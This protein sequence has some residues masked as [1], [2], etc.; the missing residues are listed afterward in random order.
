ML[1]VMTV[2]ATVFAFSALLPDIAAGFDVPVARAAIVPRV[3][4][5]WRLRSSPRSSGSPPDAAHADA[6]VIAAGLV[7]LRGGVD[8][9]GARSALRRCCSRSP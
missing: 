5:A 7:V 1:G 9:G 6:S 3:S 2:G 8:R 4:S